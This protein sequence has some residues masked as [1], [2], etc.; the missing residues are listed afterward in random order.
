MLS[1]NE[2]KLVEVLRENDNP[3]KVA[4]YMLSLFLDYLRTHG[5]SL[6]KPAADP[7]VSA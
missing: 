6:D 4:G 5:P 2:I 3:G 7:Q 1:E